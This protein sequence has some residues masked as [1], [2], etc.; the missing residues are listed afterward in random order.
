M[1]VFPGGTDKEKTFLLQLVL[2]IGGSMGFL[3]S[4]AW[5]WGTPWKVY[6]VLGVWGA[7]W[8]PLVLVGAWWKGRRAQ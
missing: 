5:A 7:W 3:Y 4:L 2:G 1:S 8:L 6:L